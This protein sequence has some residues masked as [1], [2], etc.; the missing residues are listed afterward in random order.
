VAH[1]PRLV[2]ADEPTG[3]LDAKNGQQVIALLQSL[4]ANHNTSLLLVTHSHQV[5][6]C[7]NRIL[8]MH[9]GKLVDQPK[10]TVANT[11]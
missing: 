11:W 9:D 8:A 1:E 6:Q 3:N 4:V 2:L 7:A 5:A 10:D